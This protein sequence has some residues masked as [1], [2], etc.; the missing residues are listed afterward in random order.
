GAIYLRG[1]VSRVYERNGTLMV[2]GA[3]TLSG[4]QVEMEADLVVLATAVIPR[5]GAKDLAKRLGISYDGYG[6]YS[7]Y[8]PKLRPVE[9]ATAGIFL[10]GACIGPTDI[11]AAVAQGSAS[12]SKVLAMFSSDELTR[13]PIVAEVNISTCNACWDCE[14]ACPYHAIE[15]EEIKDR[16]GGILRHVAR[17]N[18]GVCVGCG[19]CVAA[20]HSKTIDLRGYSDAQIYAAICAV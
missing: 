11:P 17:V 2:Q 3:D 4:S 13:E 6:F 15:R 7:E 12:A 14:T 8:H 16:S 9:T 20:C 10:A 19:V 18:E 5:V 1:R